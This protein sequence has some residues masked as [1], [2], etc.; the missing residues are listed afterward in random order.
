MVSTDRREGE[1]SVDED[2]RPRTS[3]TRFESGRWHVESGF[4]SSER[5][6]EGESS[7]S[8][9]PDCRSLILCQLKSA[10][11]ITNTLSL[12]IIDRV[13]VFKHSLEII[14]IS[15]IYVYI[16]HLF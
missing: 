13:V 9:H 6:P 8:S 10:P 3:E 14:A 1:G 16:L 11:I 15:Q 7:F 4:G 5:R 12:L 2:S